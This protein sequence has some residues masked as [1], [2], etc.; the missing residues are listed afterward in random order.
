MYRV[1]RSLLITIMIG[2]GMSTRGAFG[3]KHEV[4]GSQG[5][6]LSTDLD[7]WASAQTFRVGDQ[8]VFKYTKGLHSVVELA[9]KK[10]YDACD[11]S[12]ALSSLSDGSDVVK[13]DKPGHKY[14]TCGTMGHCQGGMKLKVKV[15]STD[16]KASPQASP[17]STSSSATISSAFYA[18]PPSYIMMMG[19]ISAILLLLRW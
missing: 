11:L 10:E 3:A 5:W 1:L 4:G 7:S 19:L 17:S 14:F 16:E 9:N 15:L 6:E 13:L 18:Y 8:L 12:N 2:L